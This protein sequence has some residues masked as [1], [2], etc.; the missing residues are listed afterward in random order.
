M[1]IAFGQA[2]QHKGD[3]AEL[4]GDSGKIWGAALKSEENVKNPI[5]VSVG[6]KIS[7]QTACLIV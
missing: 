1:S 7:L 5:Y 6:H 4:K 2:A 3:Y